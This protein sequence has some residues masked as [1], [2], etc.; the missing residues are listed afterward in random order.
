M[1]KRIERDI[2]SIVGDEGLMKI[3]S[4]KKRKL[5][6]AFPDINDSVSSNDSKKRR[7]NSEIS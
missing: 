2:K 1:Q 3:Q 6:E 4:N 5:S 7:L